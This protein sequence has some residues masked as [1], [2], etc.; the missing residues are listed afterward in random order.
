MGRYLKKFIWFLA[1]PAMLLT[2]MGVPKSLCAQGSTEETP[3]V[4]EGSFVA[5]TDEIATLEDLLALI[6]DRS[7]K[8]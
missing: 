8:F 4:T 3:L 5:D 1:F 6:R 2:A 7:P